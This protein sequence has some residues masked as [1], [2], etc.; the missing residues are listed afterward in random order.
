VRSVDNRRLGLKEAKDLCDMLLSG[1][2]QRLFV[3][4]K[5]RNSILRELR[6]A[7]FYV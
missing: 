7:G 4:A 3:D 2:P 6:D 5:N 1:T